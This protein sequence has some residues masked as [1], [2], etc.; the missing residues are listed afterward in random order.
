MPITTAKSSSPLRV[1]RRHGFCF[2][3][4]RERRTGAERLVVVLLRESELRVYWRV[5]FF[6]LVDRER[7]VVLFLR[8]AMQLL[9][10]HHNR[11]CLSL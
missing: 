1:S 11:I 4:L 3:L 9:T 8:L 2:L 6:R 7:D 5:V 10:S